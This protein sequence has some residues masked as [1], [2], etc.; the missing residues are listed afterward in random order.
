MEGMWWLPA[1]SSTDYVILGNPTSKTVSGS[2]GV[3]SP[4]MNRRIPLA[5]GLGQT[6]RIDLRQGLAN[7]ATT[8]LNQDAQTITSATQVEPCGV[9]DDAS[10]NFQGF[11]NFQP[12]KSCN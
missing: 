5:I 3:S 4:S 8:A 11:I 9:Q 10:C 2:L 6:K 1:L 12:Y 7:S